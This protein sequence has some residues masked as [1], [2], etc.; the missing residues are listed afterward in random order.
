MSNKSKPATNVKDD[1]VV[2]TAASPVVVVD[3][4]DVSAPVAELTIIEKMIKEINDTTDKV[5][6]D[7]KKYTT[8]AKRN[9]IL[10]KHL[11]LKVSVTTEHLNIDNDKVIFKCSISTWKKGGWHVVATGHAEESRSA[12][13]INKKAAVENA[14]TSALGRA[15]SNLGLSGGEFAS[16]NELS[17]KTGLIAKADEHLVAHVKE[18][19]KESGINQTALLGSLNLKSFDMMKEEDALKAIKKCL[20]SIS[21]KKDPKGKTV[22]NKSGKNDG[23]E[24]EIKL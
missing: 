9:E 23:Q 13:E 3:P 7:G 18:L 17:M 5:V 12:N 21:N 2:E 24:E 20:V 8:V 16:I 4:K 15:L 10:R 19:M 11:G 6:I 14:E 22:P 1:T